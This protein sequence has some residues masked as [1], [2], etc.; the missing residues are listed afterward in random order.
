MIAVPCGLILPTSPGY[1]FA[2]RGRRR[3]TPAHPVRLVRDPRHRDDLSV[4][5]RTT[6]RHGPHPRWRAERQLPTSRP[7]LHS[8]YL[9]VRAA[10][11]A[12]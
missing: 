10:M 5:R 3:L 2:R 8:G 7:A 9:A 12:I 4:E 11:A 1:G 6:A